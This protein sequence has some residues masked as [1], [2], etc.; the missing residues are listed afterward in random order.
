VGVNETSLAMFG[1]R[2]ASLTGEQA[3]EV[4]HKLEKGQ[5][6]GDTWNHLSA[7]EFFGLVLNH[8]MQ[9]FYGDPR[10]G[11]NRERVSWKML[12]LPYPPI[13]GRLRYDLTKAEGSS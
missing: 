3:D 1:K 9:S 13:R 5:A 4:L 8:T 6:P 11:G 7:K 2:V 10:H 12:R